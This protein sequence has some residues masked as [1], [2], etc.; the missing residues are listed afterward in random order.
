MVNSLHEYNCN[1]NSWKFTP[2]NPC[3]GFDNLAL[4][5]GDYF[6]AVDSNSSELTNVE[7]VSALVHDSWMRNY[8]FWRDNEPW[9][10]NPRYKKPY[11]PIKSERRDALLVPFDELSDDEKNKDKGIA[12]FLIS[13]AQ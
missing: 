5:L 12:E 3:Y 11:N 13:L 8:L 2:L 1:C 4:C 9:V 7:N 6:K 10:T